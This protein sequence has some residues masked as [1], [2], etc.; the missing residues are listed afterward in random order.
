MKT[1]HRLLLATLGLLLAGCAST[2]STDPDLTLRVTLKDYMGGNRFELVSQSQDERVAYYSQ[3]RGSADRKFQTH[4]VMDALVNE[5]ERQGFTDF[6]Q[7]G[8]A[9]SQ[10][11]AVI[12]RALEIQ[13]G[14]EVQ[15]WVVGQGSE[16]DE[17]A[18]FLGC[19]DTFVQLYN[20]TQSFQAI[21]NEK[22][23]ELFESTPTGRT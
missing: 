5:L 6:S 4:E 16:Q 11:G 12:T 13:K 15:H 1:P 8:G 21:R 19:V 23:S 14:D 7:A 10:G 2:S 20:L 17:R 3:V 9:P 18:Q 22:G